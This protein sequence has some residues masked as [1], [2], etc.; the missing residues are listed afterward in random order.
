MKNVNTQ[1]SA[2]PFI[3]IA[4]SLFIVGKSIVEIYTALGKLAY[5]LGKLARDRVYQWRDQANSPAA[6]ATVD[7]MHAI[8]N[9]AKEI[10]V[11]VTKSLKPLRGG[12]FGG[13]LTLHHLLAS[14]T[15]VIPV[16]KSALIGSDR[17][18]NRLAK[19][20]VDQSVELGIMSI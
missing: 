19:F 8:E 1:S 3:A 7:C 2:F 6:I 18:L 15:T 14:V 20:I 11:Y 5:N 4:V 17:L 16:V 9:E 13:R 12:A 10:S